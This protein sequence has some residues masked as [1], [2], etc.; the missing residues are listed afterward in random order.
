MAGLYNPP[1]QVVR[2]VA[3]RSGDAERG[4]EVRLNAFEAHLRMVAEG[5]LT[6]VYGPRRHDLAKVR[7]DDEIPRGGIV[8]RDILGLAPSEIVRLVRVDADRPI[9]TPAPN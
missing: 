6:W 1:L 9:I 5:D 2:F 7:I 3:T 8:V 4:P